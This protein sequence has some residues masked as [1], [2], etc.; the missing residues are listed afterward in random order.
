[1]AIP[2]H[3]IPLAE[4]ISTSQWPSPTFFSEYVAAP[5]VME[6]RVLSY[7]RAA[8]RSQAFTIREGL[9]C[10]G[11]LVVGAIV[12]LLVLMDCESH[13]LCHTH[14]QFHHYY[15]SATHNH[16]PMDHAP[17]YYV[18]HLL[19]NSHVKYRY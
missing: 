10:C 19:D 8:T 12:V 6:T 9:A 1:M 2:S 7:G 15:A 18:Q 17:N 16:Y 11:C 4:P 5:H 3:G 13:H 14:G